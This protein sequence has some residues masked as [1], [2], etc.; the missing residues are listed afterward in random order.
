MKRFMIV[1][2]FHITDV[3]PTPDIFMRPTKAEYLLCTKTA[4][5]EKVNPVIGFALYYEPTAIIALLGN[6]SLVTL[7]VLYAADPPKIGDMADEN[8][9][10]TSPLK[11]MLQEPFDQYIQKILKKTSTQPVLKLHSSGEHTQEQCYELLQRAAQAFREEYFKNHT[12]AREEIEKRVQT[13]SIMKKNQQKEIELMNK[14]RDI[15]Q[16]KASNLAEKYEDI[17]DKQDELLKKCENLLMLVS[18]K[19]S[20]PSDSERVFMD[21]LQLVN[22]RVVV[23]G[24]R[25]DKIKNKMKYQEIQIENW[26]AQEVKKAAII[27]ETHTN[28]IKSNLQESAKKITD[29]V[30]AVKENKSILNLK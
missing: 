3:D 17:K 28:T 14:D 19:K 11:K 15:L 10:G 13:L 18:R 7:G 2:N 24:N 8:E 16:D 25:I 9:G 1:M 4:T 23:Y 20:T 21:E 5:S 12:K 6:R 30:K 26:K 27:N 29:M 22:E